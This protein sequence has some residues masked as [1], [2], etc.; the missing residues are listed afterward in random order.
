[1]KAWTIRVQDF[2]AARRCLPVSG[3]GCPSQRGYERIHLVPSSSWPSS[4][5]ADLDPSHPF[6]V[7]FSLCCF[8]CLECLEW[9]QMRG[10]EGC[11]LRVGPLRLKAGTNKSSFYSTLKT[12]AMS[13]L[14]SSIPSSLINKRERLTLCIAMSWY[15]AMIW[16]VWTTTPTSLLF[17]EILRLPLLLQYDWKT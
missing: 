2:E 12:M 3:P 6:G 9:C 5:A 13:L 1:M 14:Y 11:L 7:A 4:Y 17:L 16:S 10:S 8:E 15:L